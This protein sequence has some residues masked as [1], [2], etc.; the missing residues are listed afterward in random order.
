MIDFKNKDELPTNVV[1]CGSLIVIVVAGACLKLLPK[2]TYK[3]DAKDRAAVR[4]I[5]KTTDD[6]KDAIVEAKAQIATETWPGIPED[7]GPVA[8]KQVN[9]LLQAHHLK[10]SGFHSQ[11]PLEQ[12]N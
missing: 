7:V 11:K 12:S 3:D 2:P 1:I 10:L 4:K 5:L 9:T 8:L 6:V